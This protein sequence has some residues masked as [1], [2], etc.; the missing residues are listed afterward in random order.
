MNRKIIV[1]ALPLLVLGLI[2]FAFVVNF[3]SYLGQ[4][5]QLITQGKSHN[6]ILVS[7]V[8]SQNLAWENEEVYSS[9]LE[10][11]AIQEVGVKDVLTGEIFPIND[12]VITLK[13]NPFDKYLTRTV[14]SNSEVISSANYEVRGKTLTLDVYFNQDLAPE[15]EVNIAFNHEVISALVSLSN[16][17][18]SRSVN[19]APN[20][21]TI[22]QKTELFDSILKEF[23]G[24]NVDSQPYPVKII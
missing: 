11:L 3:R 13:P 19:N 21:T 1:I 20:T 4:R 5:V 10:R 22:Q 15:G 12:I 6:T 23:F 17:G 2:I 16:A 18:S 9:I 14:N 7:E 8:P 24:P